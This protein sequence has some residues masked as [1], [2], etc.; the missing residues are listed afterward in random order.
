MEGRVV[1]FVRVARIL[2]NVNVLGEKMG[3]NRSGILSQG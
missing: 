1:R 2:Y 3:K